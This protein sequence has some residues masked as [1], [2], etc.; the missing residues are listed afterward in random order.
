MTLHLTGGF[1]VAEMKVELLYFDGCP[2]WKTADERLR[3][4]ATE[5]SFQLGRRMVTTP[6]EAQIAGFRGSPTILID[7]KDPFVSGDEPISL[8]C[9]VYRTPAGIAG[10]PSIDQLRSALLSAAGARFE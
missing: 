10:S 5:C 3:E 2:N 6:E 8:S 9:R 1:T 7:G 4:L